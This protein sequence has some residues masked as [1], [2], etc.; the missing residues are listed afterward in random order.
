MGRK[1]K[2]LRLLARQAAVAAVQP[3]TPAPVAVEAPVVEEVVPAPVVKE[4]APSKK[5]VEAK[6]PAKQ[7]VGKKTPLKS[8]AKKTKKA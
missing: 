1:K 2:R 8:V 5:T 3:P 6:T 4:A 7:N